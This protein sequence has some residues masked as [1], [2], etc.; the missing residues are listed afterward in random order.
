MPYQKVGWHS[1][2]D[3]NTPY[4]PYWLS[5]MLSLKYS[6]LQYQEK[7]SSARNKFFTVQSFCEREFPLCNCS[8]TSLVNTSYPSAESQNS[9]LKC[10]WVGASTG[11]GLSCSL[12]SACRGLGLVAR[13]DLSSCRLFKHTQLIWA[14]NLV[15]SVQAVPLIKFMPFSVLLK[16]NFPL[17]PLVL[18]TFYLHSPMLFKDT[19]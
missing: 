7:K 6:Y 11:R 8:T 17:L 9:L 15:I 4:W 19:I 5:W 3:L 10:L 16:F 14:L 12:W 2:I 1:D 13:P 18:L